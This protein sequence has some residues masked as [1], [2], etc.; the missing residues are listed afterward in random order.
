MKLV[1]AY[2]AGGSVRELGSRFG[3]SRYAITPDLKVGGVQL[4]RTPMA[5]SEIDEAATLYASGLPLAMVGSQLG[6][7]ASIIM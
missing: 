2:R 7:Q 4:R 6:Y 3:V 5:T 1:E